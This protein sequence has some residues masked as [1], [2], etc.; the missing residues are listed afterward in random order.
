MGPRR[1]G[2]GRH[3][4]V[5]VA[6]QY[7]QGRVYHHVFGHVWPLD[8][9]LED[10]DSPELPSNSR[11]SLGASMM[12]FENPGFQQAL[13]RGCEWAATGDVSET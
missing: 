6:L 12:A 7:G 9:I 10:K 1:A 2:S 5:M 3:E 8:P 13:I 4:P 11:A